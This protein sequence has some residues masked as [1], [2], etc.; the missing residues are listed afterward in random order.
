MKHLTFKAQP[1]A[2]TVAAP[3]SSVL[4]EIFVAR[5]FI[6]SFQ[7]P[8]DSASRSCFRQ[9][10]ILVYLLVCVRPENLGGVA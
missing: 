5:N 9:A 1:D 7:H 2:G 4:V 3:I 8:I 6:T 10:C